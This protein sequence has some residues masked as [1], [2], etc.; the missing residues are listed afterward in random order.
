MCKGRKLRV[1]KDNSVRPTPDRIKEAVFSMLSPYIDEETI[2][3]DVFSGTGNM[4]L[5]T[6]SRGAGKVFFSELSIDNIAYIKQNIAL[7]DVGDRSVVYRGD[8]A[9]N[10]KR[11]QESP[12]IY[13]L[14]PPYD[15]CLLEEA[16]QL[17]SKLSNLKNEAFIVC[18]HRTKHALPGQIGNLELWKFK[19]YGATSISIYRPKEKG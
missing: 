3:V 9:Q 17:I 14:D 19:R 1:P 2:A 12:D 5:E 8:Y 6:L 11:I 13:F 10:L 15:D 18:E 4:G 7:C 16:L